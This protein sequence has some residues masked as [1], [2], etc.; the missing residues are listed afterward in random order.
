[1][2][3]ENPKQLLSSLRIPSVSIGYTTIKIY[4]ADDLEE[5][6]IGYSVDPSGN[7]LIDENDE[8]GWKKEWLVIGYEDLCGDPIFIDTALDGFPVYTAIHGEGDWRPKRIAMTLKSFA[9]A[10]KEVATI[11]RGRE[12]A[13]DFERNPIGE[14][15]KAHFLTRVQKENPDID[16]EFWVLSLGE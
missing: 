6:Q 11:A 13:K 7:S 15:E 5:A 2:Y 4:R 16:L 1:M 3:K 9:Q 8:G 14:V 10:M 12:T